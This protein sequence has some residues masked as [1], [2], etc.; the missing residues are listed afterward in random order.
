MKTNDK[1]VAFDIDELYDYIGELIAVDIKSFTVDV[2][3]CSEEF[4][5]TVTDNG[6]E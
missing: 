3:E 5:V 6:L 2:G 1:Y 4:I